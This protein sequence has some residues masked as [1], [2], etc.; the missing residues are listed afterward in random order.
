MSKTEVVKIRLD[1]EA[2]QALIAIATRECR[3]FADQC[4][5]ALKEWLDSKG[6]KGRAK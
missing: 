4:R 2:K 3:T 1:S 5:Y 6:K